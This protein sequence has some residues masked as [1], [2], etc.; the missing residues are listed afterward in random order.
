LT[1]QQEELCGEIEQCTQNADQVQS[2]MDAVQ[3][4][5][6]ARNFALG[7][8]VRKL[9]LSVL[10]NNVSAMEGNRIERLDQLVRAVTSSQHI[11]DSK[12]RDRPGSGDLAGG[13]N[14][15]RD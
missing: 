12:V 10:R 2:E 1:V 14:N 4:E 6:G 11:R 7:N 8:I 9:H 15:M 13:V 5:V 3:R